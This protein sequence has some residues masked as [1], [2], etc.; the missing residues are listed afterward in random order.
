MTAF[1]YREC[2]QHLHGYYSS[3]I[4]ASSINGL[5]KGSPT[6]FDWIGISF[7]LAPLRI[8]TEVYT[9]TFSLHQSDLTEQLLLSCMLMP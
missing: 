7:R 4:R 3:I 2:I 6:L 1:Y 8:P 5:S 9:R